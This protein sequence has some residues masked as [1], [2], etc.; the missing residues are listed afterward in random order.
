MLARCEFNGRKD[1]LHFKLLQAA[2]EENK[3]NIFSGQNAKKINENPSDNHLHKYIDRDQEMNDEK[4]QDD[5][6]RHH[7]KNTNQVPLITKE[8]DEIRE[9]RNKRKKMSSSLIE[10]PQNNRKHDK[11]YFKQGLPLSKNKKMR[12]NKYR[13]LYE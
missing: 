9:P 7:R 5:N 13:E 11:N 6:Y 8:Y 12:K 3:A 1:V 2:I 4:E 10:E